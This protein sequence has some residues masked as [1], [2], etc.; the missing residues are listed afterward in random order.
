MSKRKLHAIAD[1]GRGLPKKSSAPSQRAAGSADQRA[2]MS[3][4]CRSYSATTA[5]IDAGIA[6]GA[7]ATCPLSS[8]SMIIRSSQMICHAIYCAVRDFGS[9]R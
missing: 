3:A 7:Q 4:L 6:G 9:G 5:A 1:A 2:M 8:A